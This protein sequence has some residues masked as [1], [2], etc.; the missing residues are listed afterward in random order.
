MAEKSVAVDALRPCWRCGVNIL[1]R[2]GDLVVHEVFKEH[3]LPVHEM[4][5]ETAVRDV[6]W[7]D[8]Q[9]GGTLE[10][11]EI[12]DSPEGATPH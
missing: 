11:Y 6:E 7:S 10:D 4:C 9:D 2:N 3:V 8:S 1:L 5:H 12:S